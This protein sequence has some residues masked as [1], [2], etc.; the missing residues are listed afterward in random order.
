LS[1]ENRVEL[2]WAVDSITVGA[3]HRQDLGD[4]QALMDSISEHGLLQPITITP[5]GVLVC[6][7]R[8][9]AAIKRLGWRQVNVW[10][11]SGL[12]DRLKALMAERDENTSHKQ[13][14]K[15]ELAGLYEELKQVIAAEAA[16]RQQAAQYGSDRQNPRS[17]GVGNLP[18][19][20][21]EPTGDSRAKAGAMVGGAYKTL[22]KVLAIK[23]VATDPH[24]PAHLRDQAAE[25]LRLIED[26]APVDPLF[27]AL[28]AGVQIDDLDQIAADDTEPV[29]AREAARSGAV[30]LR[31][32]QT[33]Q[34]MTPADLD[35][36]ARAAMDRLKAAK[37]AHKPTPAPA[38]KPRPPAGPRFRTAKAF[39]WTWTEMANWTTE[40]DP[41]TVAAA[42]TDE[43]WQQFQ[44]TMADGIAFMNRVQQARLDQA[45]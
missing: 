36:A 21:G 14:T 24:R 20:P 17:D 10:V 22:E 27:C 6:G 35:K 44:Q 18:T 16:R 39:I 8:R 26:G 23:Q 40:Y 19:P 12:S 37:R 2:D 30:L 13:Y 41:N 28:R 42:L 45:A 33:D 4:L 32:L 1:G 38:Q 9:L 43:Q 5:E 29:E 7:A 15:V 3:R 31:K 34:L 25:A 11:R